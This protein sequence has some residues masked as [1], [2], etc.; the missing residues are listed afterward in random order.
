WIFVNPIELAIAIGIPTSLFG[1]AAVARKTVPAATW[2]RLAV[3]VLL[4]FSG[5]NLSEVARLWLPFMPP[6][7]LAAGGEISKDSRDSWSIGVVLI[8]LGVQS[9][10]LQSAIEVV[11]P[12][13]KIEVGANL[14]SV[15]SRS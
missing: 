9:L 1:I 15:P 7:L 4:N 3:L 5:K 2:V 13:G 6:L 10:V 12:F 14:Q 8:A 11:Y